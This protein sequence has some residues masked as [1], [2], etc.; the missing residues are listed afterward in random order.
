MPESSKSELLTASSQLQDPVAAAK[1]CVEYA[2]RFP[3]DE[4]RFD[5]GLTLIVAGHLV[6]YQKAIEGNDLRP[7]ENPAYSQSTVAMIDLFK[8]KFPDI[9]KNGLVSAARTSDSEKRTRAGAVFAEMEAKSAEKLAVL[10]ADAVDEARKLKSELASPEQK[11]NV[12]AQGLMSDIDL[13]LQAYADGDYEGAR[14]GLIYLKSVAPGNVGI[15]HAL[16]LVHGA[17]ANSR[18]ALRELLFG[19]S[20]EPSDP[21]IAANLMFALISYSLLASALDVH[22]HYLS[23]ARPTEKTRVFHDQANTYAQ[24][25]ETLVGVIVCKEAGIEARDFDAYRVDAVAARAVVQRPWLT[26]STQSASESPLANKRIFIS[27]RRADAAD[28]A[29]RLRA[30]LKLNEPSLY[31]FVDEVEMVGGSDFRKQL[32]NE[33]RRSDFFLLLI[34]PSWASK[35]GIAQ[36]NNSSDVLRKELALALSLGKPVLPVVVENSRLPAQEDLPVDIRHFANIHAV[37]LHG[38]RFADG[39]RDIERTMRNSLASA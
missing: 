35:K 28:I 3:D 39:V 18:D 20:L 38:E 8:G 25:A 9:L 37:A 16:A 17:Q 2:K 30:A 36:L 11:R 34:G 4:T 33:I 31:I 10:F 29:R 26:S 22:R 19:F 13:Y 24:Y 15:R 32:D 23:H 6:E 1:A 14:R 5:V 12:T 27:Y 21:A 7:K